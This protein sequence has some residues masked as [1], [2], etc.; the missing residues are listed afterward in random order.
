MQSIERPGP[1]RQSPHTPTPP[2]L[3]GRPLEFSGKVRIFRH[4]IKST[5]RLRLLRSNLCT[6]HPAAPSTLTPRP[7]TAGM[8]SN[9][10][11][12][13]P[14]EG[15]AGLMKL[16]LMLNRRFRCKNKFGT[17]LPMVPDV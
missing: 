5:L 1:T 17:H 13:V 2:S 9:L 15:F 8:A 10:G 4:D 7:Q 12:D 14:E 3:T 11:S 16:A 6:T